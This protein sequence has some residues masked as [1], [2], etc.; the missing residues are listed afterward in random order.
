MFIISEKNSSTY[1]GTLYWYN[2]K[3]LKKKKKKKESVSCHAALLEVNF[4]LLHYS[5]ILISYFFVKKF[6]SR[7]INFTSATD[8]KS[9]LHSSL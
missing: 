2:N 9:I 4:L 1:M 5:N 3:C 7:Y 6:L 8:C